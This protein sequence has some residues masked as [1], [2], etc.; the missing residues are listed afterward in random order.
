MRGSRG[1][2]TAPTRSATSC[3]ERGWEVRDTPEGPVLGAG[4]RQLILYGRN[5]VLEA[6]RG[7]R[8]G[9]PRLG[10]G[11]SRSPPR[12]AS[13]RASAGRARR[14]GGARGALRLAVAPGPRVRGRIRIPTPT[15]ARCCDGDQA[16]VVAL[17]QVQDPQNLGAVCRS[18]EAR[19]RDRGRDPRAAR[20]GGHARRLP[21]LRRRGRAP[22]RWPGCATWPTTSA[23]AKQRRAPG[24]TAPTPGRPAPT[25]TSTGPGAA[26]L[27]LGSEGKGL[28]PR[29]REA[30]DDLLSVPLLG[31]V[32][33]LNV[34]ATAA[35]LLYEAVRSRAADGRRALDK[36]T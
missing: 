22:A 33:S 14:R 18:A 21:R 16:L 31:R 3:C 15:P 13:A 8:R 36:S 11:R 12:C 28:R 9:A 24:S 34:A 25:R 17:D 35:I 32:E 27:V 19:G 10:R 5:A 6:L 29:V 2:S 30:C 4:R 23:Q 1:T 7:R 20:R 26:V